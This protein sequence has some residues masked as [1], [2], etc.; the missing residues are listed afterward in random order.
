MGSVVYS[1][2]QVDAF[3]EYI[4]LP[5]EYRNATPSLELLYALH[6][7]TISALPYENL[8]VHYNPTHRVSIDP[9]VLFDKI[10]GTKR[11]RGGYCMEVSLFYNKMLLAMGFQA[12]TVGART[13]R[14]LSGT[15]QG[16]YPGW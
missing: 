13:R 2:E 12:Y 4:Q 5:Q 9:Q 8:S 15:P 11:G 3:L 6:V 14:R 10:V 1:P 16:D 7:H